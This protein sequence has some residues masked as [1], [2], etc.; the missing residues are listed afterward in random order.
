MNVRTSPRCQITR[1][2]ACLGVRPH[3]ALPVSVSGVTGRTSPL[4]LTSSFHD[5]FEPGQTDMFG[6]E[7]GSVGALLTVHVELRSVMPNRQWYLETVTVAEDGSQHAGHLF[8]CY[9]WLTSNRPVVLLR[10][11]DGTLPLTYRPTNEANR[12]IAYVL[13][14][15]FSY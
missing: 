14:V 8:P 13:R 9:A 6:V 4:N 12:H 15:G 1:R 5:D 7:Y 10:K 3:A 2:L 11:I